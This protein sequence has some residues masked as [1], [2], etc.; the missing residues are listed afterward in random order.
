MTIK[1]HQ[2]ILK[3]RKLAFG[4]LLLLGLAV[5]GFSACEQKDLC[6]DHDHASN[7]RVSFD[8]RNDTTANPSSMLVYLLPR[9]SIHPV[10]KRELIGKD[11]GYVQASVGVNYSALGFNSGARNTIFSYVPDSCSME[12]YSKAADM[13]E[14]IGVSVKDLPVTRGTEGQRVVLE[15]DSL[16]SAISEKDIHI[17]LEQNDRGETCD[18]TLVP[19][20]MFRTYKVKILNVENAEYIFSSI[21]GSL[22]GLASGINLSTGESINESVT[23]GFG[24][25]LNEGNNTLDGSFRCHGSVSDTNKLDIYMVLRD[26]T[27]WCYS[28]DVTQQVKDAPDPYNVEIVL[29][30]L[31]IPN[32]IGGN[33]GLSPGVSDWNVIDIPIDM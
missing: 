22:S 20:R 13:I 15:A 19:R 2:H 32:E 31:P 6:Y 33:S 24:M 14:S 3:R 21:A 18:L 25:W 23:V 12:A 10:L 26:G 9:D 29:D 17:S 1:I 30:N 11:G 5:C 7:V 8:W 16:W 28:Y 4:R 27:K